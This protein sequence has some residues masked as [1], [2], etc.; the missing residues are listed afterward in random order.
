MTNP[1]T[2]EQADPPGG[3]PAA[4][5][6][7]EPPPPPEATIAPA[8]PAAPEPEEEEEILDMG[9]LLDAGEAPEPR[10]LRR[11]EVI[12]G[13]VMSIER[14][15]VLID[16]VD[17]GSKSEGIVPVQEMHSLGSDPLSRLSIGENVLVYVMQA[18]TE[19]GQVQ[20]SI[21]RARGEQGWRILQERFESGE[22]FEAEITG[23]N[24]GGLLA[25][26]EGV[27]TFIPMSQV[28]GA[29][30]GS[31]GANPLS[32]QVGRRLRMKVIEINRR[33]NRAI[34]S[35]RAA[36]QEWRAEQKERLLGELTEGEV[37][38]GKVTSIRNFG[39]FV[40]LGG[41]DGLAHLSELSWDRNADPEQ[42]FDIGQEI[43][44]FVMRIDRENK[45]I[46]LSVRRAAPEQWQDLIGRYEV[47]D[48]VP[49]VVTK[50]VAFG[51][52]TRLP[53][54]VEGLAHVSELVDRRIN[55]PDEILTE[56]DV[57]PL[58][59]VRIE[60]DRHRLGLSLREGRQEAEMRGWRFDDHGRVMGVADEARAEFPNECTAVEERYASRQAEAAAADDARAEARGRRS[61][62]GDQ[63][64]PRRADAPPMTAMAAAMQQAREELASQGAPEE[65]PA[66]EAP[67]AEAPA[68]EAPAAE[69]PVAEAPAA[70]APAA[71]APAAEAPAAEAPAAEAPA[72]EA[73]V[74]EAPAP[75]EAP[76]AEA[77][78]AEAPAAEAPAAEA[79]AAEAPA[80][81]APAAEAP[82]AEAPAAEAPAAEAA[83]APAAEARPRQRNR[84]RAWRVPGTDRRPTVLRPGSALPRVQ[85]AGN[86]GRI[87]HLS[88][89]VRRRRRS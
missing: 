73:P 61:G 75:E 36:M 54:P 41:A 66:A 46:A 26:V 44:V 47:G 16:L 67:A 38:R 8:P 53:G 24:K 62:G 20:L 40:D 4:V 34:L 48:V 21:D 39:V 18:E 43:D 3:A 57:V 87:A 9:A 35:E 42:L 68:A 76:A 52:F 89:P 58:K 32:D 72:A 17:I 23:F 63:A 78:A 70:E 33:R 49:G 28:V 29:K 19:D 27:N 7:P 85:L 65:A 77:P 30:P 25:N 12:E 10:Q 5:A 84:R 13:P 2:T 51:A 74:A 69:A 80:A 86:A 79:P 1:D 64:A 6:A 71:E 11:G 14:D 22:I 59:I 31:D 83:E 81:E 45:K 60:H 82:A 37:R 15:G 88:S 56:G 50:V 55:A